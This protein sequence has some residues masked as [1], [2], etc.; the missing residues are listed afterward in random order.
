MLIKRKDQVKT[1]SRYYRLY[2]TP[3][4]LWIVISST[5]IIVIYGLKRDAAPYIHE[6]FMTIFSH[7]DSQQL[8]SRSPYIAKETELMPKLDRAFSRYRERLGPMLEIKDITG[9]IRI[10]HDGLKIYYTGKYKAYAVF[11]SG[12]AELRLEIIREKTVWNIM[13]FD[14]I[15]DKLADTY[16]N[17]SSAQ[18]YGREKWDFDK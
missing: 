6:A 8:F 3:I 11:E 7:F 15:S 14:L 16:K 13:L 10:H 4:I 1:K 9:Q 12:T 17:K 18:N 2:L 5:H